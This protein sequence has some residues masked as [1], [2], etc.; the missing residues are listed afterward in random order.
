[1]LPEQTR[2]S[3][4]VDYVVAG[5]GELPFA[6]LIAARSSSNRDPVAIPGVVCKAD[7]T[8]ISTAPRDQP[9]KIPEGS[10]MVPFGFFDYGPHVVPNPL[11]GEQRTL[12][13]ISS[14]GCPHRCSFCSPS[15]SGWRPYSVAEIVTAL[16]RLK[17]TLAR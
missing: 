14:R 11:L 4:L 7:E 6:R 9:H 8:K 5:D 3:P 13:F 10:E 15:R 17:E 12:E 1:M 16:E 2:Q